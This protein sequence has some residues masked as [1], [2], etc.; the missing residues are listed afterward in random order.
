LSEAP[1]H[2][3]DIDSDFESSKRGE[4]KSYIEKTFGEK[5]VVSV[6]T[7]STVRLKGA[8]KDFDRQLS[9][10]IVTANLMTSII[11]EGDKSMVDLFKRA[12]S[13]P[14]LKEYIK[15]N[16][17]IF[18]MLPSILN[19][20]KTKS[21]HP[22]AMVISPE[23]L[24]S[25]EWHPNRVQKG[26]IVSEWDGRE[27]E[28]AGFLKQDILG[29][30]QIDKISE[31]LK[32]IEKN[33]KEK[34]DIYHLPE[35]PEVYRYFSNGWNGDIFQ[36]GTDSLSNYTK[37]MKP[38]L[39][40]D[41]IAVVSLHRPGPMENH[42]HEI[43][44]KCKNEGRKPVYLWGTEE[45]TRDTFGLLIYQEQILEVCQKLGGLTLVE[46]DDVRRAMG[47]KD[48]KYL[49]MWRDRLKKGYLKNGATEK[50][51]DEAW[52]VMM[53]FAKYSFNRSHAACYAITGYIGQWLKVH[54]PLEFW[55]VALA[56]ADEKDTLKYLSEIFMSK[57]IRVS[58]P[59]INQS[60]STTTSDKKTNTIYWG[61]E[62]IKGIGETTADQI[63][64]LRKE[65]GEYKS[66]ADF[67]FRNAFTG[68]KVKKQTIEALI[69][70]GA[71]DL[72][73]GFEN[74]EE[75][76]GLLISRYRKFKQVK[77]SNPKRDPYTIG[78]LYEKWWW[79]LMQKKLTGFVFVDYG[80]LANELGI[81]TIPANNSELGLNQNGGIFRS[82]GGY[83][84]ECKIRS[85]ARGR[86]AAIL[87]ESN[88]KLYKLMLWND[89]YEIYKDD[90][91]N[92]E[93][94]FIIFDAQLRYEA[95]WVKGNQFTLQENSKFIVLN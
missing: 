72:L 77:V 84:I 3:S 44:V 69:S 73:Y 38:Q 67:Y 17:D 47:K 60:D 54:F 52:Q 53:E 45:I 46:A 37:Y 8:L 94:S 34:P 93:K 42:Y 30:L 92:I 63:I 40:A 25:D 48:L 1:C 88:Y 95:K 6:G 11:D 13:E 10:D 9:N 18:Y 27:M 43:Y 51:F 26:M 85:S 80:I 2:N 59:D 81:E 76:R 55:T 56:H 12:A 33:G 21:I 62:S 24:T 50:Q 19:Q 7:V 36:M 78:Q 82:F 91:K 87:I 68:S 83:V 86:F 61:I 57:N 71:F 70:S 15:R 16:S 39:L 74:F 5:Q 58:P 22:C 89:T 20:P 23:T 90:L 64:K 35:D 66:F 79:Q 65:G 14:K 28:R 29:L 49:A 75:K 4:V 31:I 41:L 32:L